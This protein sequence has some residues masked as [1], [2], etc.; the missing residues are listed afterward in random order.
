MHAEHLAVDDGGQG[1]EVED[2]ATGLPYGRI[3]V[4]L[5]AFFV[6]TIDLCDLPRLMVAADER[7][8]VRVSAFSLALD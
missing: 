3:A 4:L 8:A 1:E 6:E 7:N 5:L 2:L